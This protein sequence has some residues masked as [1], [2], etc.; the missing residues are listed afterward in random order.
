MSTSFADA[1]R[2]LSVS[3]LNAPKGSSRAVLCSDCDLDTTEPPAEQEFFQTTGYYS[4]LV[5]PHYHQTHPLPNKPKT[6]RL[7]PIFLGRSQQDDKADILKFIAR[8]V[9]KMQ[10]RSILVEL[11]MQPEMEKRMLRPCK[12]FS[13]LRVLKKVLIDAWSASPN[14]DVC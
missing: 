1:F 3:C 10:F 7:A 11:R 13:S 12:S 4:L 8:S 14:G 2:I 5:I 9:E 6:A